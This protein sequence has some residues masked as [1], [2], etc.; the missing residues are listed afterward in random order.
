MNN[1]SAISRRIKKSWKKKIVRYILWLLPLPPLIHIVFFP[2]IQFQKCPCLATNNQPGSSLE[3]LLQKLKLQYFGHLMWR[4]DTLEKTLMLAGKYWRQ[5]EKG[6]QRM[7]W[8]DSITDSMDMSLSKLWEIVEDRETWCGA[9]HGVVESWTRLNDW[10]AKHYVATHILVPA[11]GS[12]CQF[13]IRMD[14]GALLPYDLNN[15]S[16]YPQCT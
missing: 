16:K 15:K 2:Y 10:T 8:L 4:V 13:M 1:L 3:G 11:P 5:K 6:Q 12:L 9:V 14:E 7:R